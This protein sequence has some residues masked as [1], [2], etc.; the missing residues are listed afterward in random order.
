MDYMTLIF[1]ALDN[2]PDNDPGME[3]ILYNLNS[4]DLKKYGFRLLNDLYIKEKFS[5]FC[6]I[7]NKIKIDK[8]ISF[9]NNNILGKQQYIN[10]VISEIITTLNNCYFQANIQKLSECNETL[11]NIILQSGKYIYNNNNMG[12]TESICEELKRSNYNIILA[13][14]FCKNFG[15]SSVEKTVRLYSKYNLLF[16]NNKLNKNILNNILPI[17]I[18]NDIV[19]L[20]CDVVKHDVENMLDLLDIFKNLSIK[21]LISQKNIK[22]IINY[23]DEFHYKNILNDINLEY[24]HT[25][26]YNYYNEKK[27]FDYLFENNKLNRKILKKNIDNII[28]SDNFDMFINIVKNNNDNIYVLLDTIPENTYL[29]STY[30]HIIG[31]FSNNYDN[32]LE[33]INLKYWHKYIYDNY[34]QNKDII[35]LKLIKNNDII[36]EIIWNRNNIGNL[37][38]L[39]LSKDIIDINLITKI[40]L[41]VRDN[42]IQYE[43]ENQGKLFSLR[44]VNTYNMYD[45][46]V[47]EICSIENS[48][49]IIEQLYKLRYLL[50]TNFDNSYN[51]YAGNFII[52]R[53]TQ[54]K[55]LDEHELDDIDVMVTMKEPDE[56]VNAKKQIQ[57]EYMIKTGIYHIDEQLYK[58]P[59]NKQIL[60]RICVN[61][62][63][64]VFKCL[65]KNYQ[66]I[67]IDDYKYML[68]SFLDNLTKNNI[69]LL[70]YLLN[71]PT[72]IDYLNE[73]LVHNYNKFFMCSLKL[74]YYN[75]NITI[76]NSNIKS[77]IKDFNIKSIID[78]K[79]KILNILDYCINNNVSKDCIMT[80]LNMLSPFHDNYESIKE[81]FTN[82]NVKEEYKFIVEYLENIACDK[83]KII[84]DMLEFKTPGNY[85]VDIDYDTIKTLN[86]NT[87]CIQ[88]ECFICFEDY[89][90]TDGH[91]NNDN[92]NN[93]NNDN[94]NNDNSNNN[95]NNDNKAII[96][97]YKIKKNIKIL[98]CGHMAHAQCLNSWNK[99]NDLKCPICL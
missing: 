83:N 53:P 18:N 99:N 26:I 48:V 64:N 56:Y 29:E 42:D 19:K 92:E 23:T 12:I 89:G 51:F 95:D 90:Q 31:K 41:Q 97:N 77:T 13:E 71:N 36:K 79:K 78:N 15:N 50:T 81:Y 14:H 33:N 45:N 93:G 94:G 44:K 66:A 47:Y 80:Y 52:N 1:N 40:L 68:D 58:I 3:Q 39:M 98:K 86:I 70:I 67:L 82:L 34:I 16:K 2:M 46:L 60:T 25:S 63:I 75:L 9:A 88:C 20:L 5:F 62:N 27:K 84:K 17:Y 8:L 32:I 87:D 22:V 30:A 55:I 73:E 74:K 10:I 49:L 57:L 61:G 72:T 69:E 59:L 38:S 11:L 4:R 24:Y 21:S 6:L 37:I 35:I 65:F 54:D 43:K 7:A 76:L 28:K 91:T 96:N 85:D